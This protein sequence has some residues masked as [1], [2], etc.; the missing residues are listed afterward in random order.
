MQS[1]PPYVH[2]TLDASR[3]VNRW[4]RDY[5]PRLTV[6]SGDTVTLDMPD[7]SGGQVRPDWT[8]EDFKARFDPLQVHALVGPIAVAGA[9]P[10]DALEIRIQ[11]YRHKGWAWTALIPPLG[12]LPEDFPRHHLLIWKLDGGCTRSVPG[13]TLDLHPFAGII[14]LQRAETGEFRTRAPGP[15][16]GNM[17]VRHLGAGSTLWLPVLTPGGG[18][19][20]GD[21]HAAQGD[22]EVCINGMEAPMEMTFSVHLHKRHPLAGP[23]LLTTP[24]LLPPRYTSKPFH[25]F[26][27]SDESPREAAKRATRRAIDYLVRRIGC[28]REVAYTVCSV[29]LDLRLS[30]LVNV[31]T[32]TVTAYLPEAI[33]DR[34]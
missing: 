12:L 31:P 29:V 27:E 6:E 32:T 25:A 3:T 14:G 8:V 7:S 5:T 26:I 13:L 16:G 30:Q 21:C 9:E 19:C 15:F 22:G 18:L 1:Q 10:G 28:T 23:Q 34:S 33:F 17:D 24:A 11:E 20:A 4:N 2:H